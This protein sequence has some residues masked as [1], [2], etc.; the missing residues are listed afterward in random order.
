M[1]DNVG[2]K[3]PAVNVTVNVFMLSKQRLSQHKKKF[4]SLQ[5]GSSVGSPLSLANIPSQDKVTSETVCLLCYLETIFRRLQLCLRDDWIKI[6]VCNRICTI[7]LYTSMDKNRSPYTQC[8]RNAV[9]KRV[10]TKGGNLG[11]FNNTCG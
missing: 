9:K 11:T 10:T 3:R 4:V 6:I 8:S 2:A 7:Y 1:Y 5:R